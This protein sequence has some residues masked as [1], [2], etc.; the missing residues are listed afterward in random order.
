MA[1]IRSRLVITLIGLAVLSSIAVTGAA[2]ARA[3]V[4]AAVQESSDGARR[5]KPEEVRELLEKNKAV[6]VDV[7]GEASYKAGHIKGARN[8]PFS[9]IRTR[10]KELPADKMIVTY[11][12]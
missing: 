11:C 5:I 10:A 9:E 4:A 1:Y 3:S 8:I 2:R 6:L 12:S 7:R